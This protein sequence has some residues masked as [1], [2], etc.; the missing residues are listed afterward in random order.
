MP[1][2]LS[3]SAIKDIFLHQDVRPE[4]CSKRWY[5]K[6]VL[7]LKEKRS[8]ISKSMTYGNYGEYLCGVNPWSETRDIVLG[9]SGGGKLDKE[10]I[11]KQS[12]WFKQ[13]VHRAGMIVNPF[14]VQQR[15]QCAYKSEGYKCP[16]CGS[17][18]N[19]EATEMPHGSAVKW[20]GTCHACGHVG[21]LVDMARVVIQGTLDILTP[22]TK[23][24][25]NN[26]PTVR[27]PLGNVDVK[28]CGNIMSDFG[29]HQWLNPGFRDHTQPDLYAWIFHEMFGVYLPAAYVVMDWSPNKNFD[30]THKWVYHDVTDA[31][32]QTVKETIRKTID[33]IVLQYKKGWPTNGSYD[34]CKSCPL[35]DRGWPDRTQPCPGRVTTQNTTTRRTKS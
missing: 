3:S 29:E 30:E 24:D 25:E 4:H 35:L 18:S 2:I 17:K 27:V 15:L 9:P 1:V 31:A 22:Y 34:K 20:M 21:D 23:F 13:E 5:A 19:I 14:S 26:V 10:R 12:L 33:F 11:Y 6:Y 8:A 7:L 32:I 16:S 28:F